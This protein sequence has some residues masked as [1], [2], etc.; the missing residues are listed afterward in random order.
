MTKI[1]Y[2]KI[3]EKITEKKYG[4][5]WCF[6]IKKLLLDLSLEEI[7]KKQNDINE[8]NHKMHKKTIMI[9]LTEYFRDK[10]IKSAKHSNKGLDYLELSK[11]NCERKRYLNLIMNDKS[12]INMLKLRTGNH[13]LLVETK[14]YG[15]RKEYHERICNLCNLDKVQDLH[16]VINECP[17]FEEERKKYIRFLTSNNNK[18]ELYDHLANLTRNK[19]KGITDFM[20]IVQ[21]NL[22]LEK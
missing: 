11:F 3:Q 6:Q 19:V 17:K 8:T 10:W 7:W 16:H 14:R 5:T 20:Q 22:I 2:N 9:S 4:K 21:N 12:V 18:Y 1:L 13:S 15:N